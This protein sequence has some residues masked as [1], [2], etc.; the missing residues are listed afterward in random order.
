M[1]AHI[2]RFTLPEPAKALIAGALAGV[3]NGLFGA[4]GGLFLVPLLIRWLRQEERQ[5]F[6]T[7]LAVI[8]PLSVVGVGLY[9]LRGALDVAACWPYLAGGAVGGVLAG[10][11]FA[12]IPVIW[13]RRAFGLLLLYGGVKAVLL[14]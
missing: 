1:N 2:H 3:A 7:S 11:V 14:L 5:A 8:L 10:P 13:L 9:A 6:A 4:G 12:R